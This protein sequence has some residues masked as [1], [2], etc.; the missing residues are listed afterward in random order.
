MQMKAVAQWG[1]NWSGSSG[2]AATNYANGINSTTKDWA[3]LTVAQQATMQSN[4]IASLPTW[5]AHVQAVGTAGWKAATVA[6]APN[7][8]QGFTAGAAN[9]NTAAQKIFN[10]LNSIV[11]SLPPRGTYAENL[12]RLTAELNALHALKGTLGAK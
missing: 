12:N 2:K 4:W 6:K 8:I 7:Y 9:Y 1:Q 5:A 10:A 11:P 3:S